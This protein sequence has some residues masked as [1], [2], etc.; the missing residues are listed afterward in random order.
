[1]KFGFRFIVLL[2]FASVLAGCTS[3]PQTKS[4]VTFTGKKGS[5][6]LFPITGAR[7]EDGE[8]IISS[9]S[10][11]RV[12]REAF[13]KLTP[14]TQ[15]NIA[16]IGFE[17]GFQQYSFLTDPD[18]IFEIG[19]D[20][21]ADYV[22]A[23]HLANFG[24]QKLVIISIM[25]VESLQ[26]I[27]GVF[28]YYN[29]LRE[30]DSMIPEI[31][32][33]LV[34]AVSKDTSNLLGLSVPPFNISL[35]VNENDSMVLA[36]ILS[37]DL[38]NAG[39]FA[40]L[41]RTDNI[42]TVMAEHQRQRSGNFDPERVKRLG[43]GHNAKYV[44]SGKVELLD[45]ITKLA[46][47][48][49]DIEDGSLIDGYERSYNNYSQGIVLVSELAA[50]LTGRMSLEDIRKA[51]NEAA[52]KAEAEAKQKEKERFWDNILSISNSE[53]LFIYPYFQFTTSDE[54]EF[55][56]GGNEVAIRFSPLPLTTIGFEFRIGGGGFK[57]ERN[58]KVN[59][60]FMGTF[61]IGIAP[62][63][64]IVFPLIVKEEIII[65]LFGNFVADFSFL[66][67]EEDDNEGNYSWERFHKHEIFPF[68]YSPG[69]ETGITF[70]WEKELLGLNL[71]YR[72]DYHESS[73]ASEKLLVH[74]VSIGLAFIFEKTKNKAATEETENH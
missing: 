60:E 15:A 48:I 32:N 39:R 49:L 20:L 46:V 40:V 13:D 50:L 44:L 10:R 27:A 43:I 16:A 42:Q 34:A 65:K 61:Y 21:K 30:I 70:Q 59:D 11:Q 72:C 66:Y 5:I 1:M 54:V 22:I 33:S 55:I 69:F 17:R 63:V 37:C 74:S 64:G 57:F 73:Y 9:L 24:N 6:A 41:P 8:A 47:D 26:Q 71:K 38:S 58:Y 31:A 4:E 53:F 29:T 45:D 56:G 36:Q 12:M 62:T 52:K 14:L 3:V 67:G 25:G 35:N 51:E 68:A 23:G 2:I 28:R 18:T 19:R 7:P